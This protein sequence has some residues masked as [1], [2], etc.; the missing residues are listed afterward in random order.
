MNICISEESIRT[1]QKCLKKFTCLKS[2]MDLCTIKTCINNKIHFIEPVNGE[3]CSF[4]MRFGNGFVCNCP[5]RK[6][7]FNNY[8]Q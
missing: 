7:L 5:V 6:E 1:A 3:Y 8:K 2:R 4:K